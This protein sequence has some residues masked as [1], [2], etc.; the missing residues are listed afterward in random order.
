VS[1]DSNPPGSTKYEAPRLERASG[2]FLC[3]IESRPKHSGRL[4]PKA[5]RR[6]VFPFLPGSLP[7]RRPMDVNL[8]LS[9]RPYGL[10]VKINLSP[11]SA[12]SRFAWNR[13]PPA[14]SQPRAQQADRRVGCGS[15]RS[16]DRHDLLAAPGGWWRG[17][18]QRY[19]RLVRSRYARKSAAHRTGAQLDS[20][21]A[22]CS[23][24]SR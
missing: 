11:F 10:R 20:L 19:A 24:A 14:G 15:G 12:E 7:H 9:G 4:S 6:K 22:P 13:A 17:I 18:I 21:A 2:L 23:Q 16:C 1:L 8:P 5:Y 3:R